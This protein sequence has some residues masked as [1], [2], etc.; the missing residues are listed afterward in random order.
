[1]RVVETARGISVLARSD[2]LAAPV[3][4]LSRAGAAP[5]EAPFRRIESGG[6]AAE[7]VPPV[8]GLWNASILDRGGSLASFQIAVNGGLGG[9]RSDAAAALAAH[10]TKLF[11]SVH[12]PCDLAGRC[13][14]C[15]PWPARSCCG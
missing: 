10:R 14:S 8:H 2:N 4:L 9:V 3:L 5:L 7:L 15:P 11:R 6:W 13:S 1:M 12:L